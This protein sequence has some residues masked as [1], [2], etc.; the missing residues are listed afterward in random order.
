MNFDKIKQ[1]LYNPPLLILLEPRR[2]LILHLTIM[3]TIIGYVLSEHDDLGRK[4]QAI[5]YWARSSLKVNP[6]TPS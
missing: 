1:Y 4:E 3:E 2:P 5:Y 6:D